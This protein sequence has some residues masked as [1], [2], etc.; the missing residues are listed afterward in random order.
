MIIFVEKLK[1]KMYLDN[2]SYRS[3]WR[4]VVETRDRKFQIRNARAYCCN[5]NCY[6]ARYSQRRRRSCRDRNAFY[7]NISRKA[8]KAK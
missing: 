5:S 7:T 8:K 1:E 2:T 4:S 6:R 3:R